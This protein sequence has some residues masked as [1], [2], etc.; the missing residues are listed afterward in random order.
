MGSFALTRAL[1]KQDGDQNKSSNPLQQASAPL[2]EEYILSRSLQLH[3]FRIPC[4]AYM[5]MQDSRDFSQVSII[6]VQL[7][8]GKSQSIFSVYVTCEWMN[9]QLYPESMLNWLQHFY[10]PKVLYSKIRFVL[11]VNYQP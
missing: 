10:K 1:N 6:R 9:M 2:P 11:A 7:S 3:K 4:L 5:L 8:Y